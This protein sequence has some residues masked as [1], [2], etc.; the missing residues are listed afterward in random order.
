MI[1]DLRGCPTSAPDAEALTSFETA[2]E[3][4]YRYRGDPLALI[5]PA[6]KTWP[7]W[8]LLHTFKAIVL[9]G[10]TER[11][12]ARAAAVSLQKA[13]SL[14]DS[15]TDRERAMHAAAVQMLDGNWAEAGGIFE[16]LLLDN[17]LDMLA[18]H[19]AQNL[20]FFTGDLWSLRNR[21]NRLLPYWQPGT[22][23]YAHVLGM[24]AFGL[25]ECNH[26]LEAEATARE[27]LALHPE[28][29]WAVHA[30]AHVLEMQGRVEEGIAHLESGAPLWAPDSGFAYHNWWHLTLFYLERGDDDQVLALYDRELAEPEARF[31]L[32]MVDAA[33]LLWRLQ[34]L[35][36]E[37]GDR[38][39]PVA[40]WWQAQID[41]GAGYYAFN[42]FHAAIAL[43]LVGDRDGLSRLHNRLQRETGEDGLSRI[44]RG[45]G[46]P[47]VAAI[48]DYEAGNHG[49]AT[50]SLTQ[51]RDRAQ[52][53][54]GSH[55]QR[56]LITL[57][58][59]AA[60]ARAGERELASRYL[61]ERR[62]M[63][64]E[65]HLSAR[66]DQRLNELAA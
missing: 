4:L 25:E 40:R 44:S 47:L 33:A 32:N 46:L 63:K 56:D 36:V 30:L 18:L 45:I 62:V 39:L 59:L 3:S 49:A 66:L 21:V 13:A 60:A 2:L 14:L 27:S 10:F 42:D 64:P 54:G 15:A 41:E 34:L 22:E 65:S 52:Q 16:G 12:F 6:L 23:G 35:G 24:H 38:A 1:A 37:I 29:P 51:L 31:A 5:K 58:L 9:L 53:F 17:P 28:N 19:T 26:Y 61:N 57:T 11:R 20:D 48:G 7:D 55:A 8:S 43:A 50:R